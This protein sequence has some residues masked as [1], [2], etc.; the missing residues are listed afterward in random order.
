[1]LLALAGIVG[2]LLLLTYS[3]GQ[4]VTGAARVAISLRLS[5]VVV[6][7]VVIGFGTSAPEMLV[8]GLAGAQDSLDLAVGN[9]VG[10]NVAN[11][12]LVLGGAALITPIA[13]RVAVLKREAVLSLMMVA[14]FG[15]MIQGGIGLS[16]GL[17]L[18]A[19]FVV[20][21]LVIVVSARE[22]DDLPA[23]EV[24]EFLAGATL[25]VRREWAR[26]ALGLAGTLAA[27]QVLVV[28]STEAAALLGLAEGFIGLTVVAVGTSLPELAASIQ[29]ARRQETDLIVGN[30]LGSNI[31]NAG[32][33]G[34]IAAF[35]GAGQP[36]SRSVTGLGV[37]LM[38]A[39]A[40]FATLFMVTGRQVVRWEGAVLLVAYLA[41]LPLLVD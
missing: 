20:L 25:S 6:G 23:S 41:V 35:T 9:I 28:S 8:S 1:M 16:G 21:L 19:V 38:V 11:L 14:L 34:A 22:G 3:A 5:R 7:A 17:V 13:V 24:D 2:G 33:V 37:G 39:V 15:L 12:T 32:A 40:L 29:A 27:S 31:F 30:L 26:I 10:S 4:F 36:M 18:A